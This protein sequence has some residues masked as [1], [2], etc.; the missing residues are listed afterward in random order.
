[1]NSLGSI[2]ILAEK[3][4][5]W[6]KD[7]DSEESIA[8]SSRIRLARNI[9][10][11]KFPINS[12]D[13]ER[14]YVKNVI[15]LAVDNSGIIKEPLSFKIVEL[16]NIDRRFLMERH[17]VSKDFCAGNI[18]SELILDN[19]ESFG[20]MINEEDHV[21]MQVFSAGFSLKKLWEKINE[22]DTTLSEEVSFVFDSDLGYL[23]SC[24]TNVGTGMRASVML[25]LPGLSLLEHLP[26]VIRGAEKLG[27]TVRG[28]YGEGSDT[29]GCMYQV[30]NQSTLGES[31]EEIIERLEKLIH[32]IV[33]SEK[34]ARQILFRTKREF[35]LDVIGRAYG[36]LK[37]SHIISEKESLKFLSALRMGVD[38]KM[39]SSL[40]IGKVN[41]LFISVQDSHLQKIYGRE[42][43]PSEKDGCRAELLRRKLNT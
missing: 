35:V 29:I 36:A 14:E 2:K 8:L 4:V 41:E 39:F 37:Y 5:I 21:R 22:K 28:L 19:D 33:L 13:T 16:S 40:N 23:T 30:S 11:L 1:M 12:S 10:N 25:N 7:E 20:I 42:L 15:A 43:I 32:Q 18:G 26:G 34:N 9:T 31:E 38:M 17:L 6:L 24:P 27:M 3:P